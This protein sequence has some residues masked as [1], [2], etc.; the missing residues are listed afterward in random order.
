MSH[1]N[2]ESC[3]DWLLLGLLVTT[4]FILFGAGE[5][6]MQRLFIAG[7]SVRSRGSF[8]VNRRNG[9]SFS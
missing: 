3:F 8:Y 6:A 5:L 9:R 4:P 2:G 7:F 1:D